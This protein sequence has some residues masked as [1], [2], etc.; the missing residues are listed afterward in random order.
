MIESSDASLIVTVCGVEYVP[1][2]TPKVG[3]AAGG[4]LMT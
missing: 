2:G 3:V 4:R 1:P